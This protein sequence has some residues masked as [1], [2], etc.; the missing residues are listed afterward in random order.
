MAHFINRE[1]LAWAAGFLDGEGCFSYTESGRHAC[2]SITQTERQPLERFLA[3]VG[4]G[5]I[6]R[7]YEKPTGGQWRRKPQ[8]VFRVHRQERVQAI[9]AMLWFKLGPIKRRQALDALRRLPRRCRRGHRLTGGRSCPRCVAD[10]WESKRQAKR[11]QTGQA[12]LSL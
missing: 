12:S 6:Y 7:P 1:E 8:Y 3:A 5:R 9:A 4:T 2:V 11:A 10:A